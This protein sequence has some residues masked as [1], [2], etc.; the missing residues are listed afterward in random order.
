MWGD[1]AQ[2]AVR[3]ALVWVI[4]IIVSRFQGQKTKVPQSKILPTV[5]YSLLAALAIL[6]FTLSVQKTTIANTLFSSNATEMFTA[7]L[8]G[9]LLLNESLTKRKLIAI[10]L[11]LAGLALYADSLVSGSTGL[12]FGLLAGAT[13][14]V[15]NLLAKQLKGVDIGAILRM[16][17]GIGTF[18][19][20]VLMLI[21]SSDDIVRS[22][23]IEGAVITIIF[24]LILIFATHLVLYGFQNSDINIASVIL[25]SQLAIG[26]ILGYLFFLE[27][28]AP[29]EIVSGLLIICAAIIGG[30]GQKP[31]LKDVPVH[32]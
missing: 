25:S 21:F 22:V 13:V 11:S 20:I 30:T 24:A 31:S 8:L 23:T 15:C 9:T 16:Q 32:S 17:F 14:G 2:I 7:F 29:Y 1:H 19:M 10:V 28:P 3:F 4:L 5:V 26:A 27:V 6:F 12:I 18:F